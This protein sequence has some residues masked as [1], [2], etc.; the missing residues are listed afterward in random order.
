MNKKCLIVSESFLPL[1]I[2][3]STR[4]FVLWYKNRADIIDSHE[5]VYLRSKYKN[6]PCPSVVRTKQKVKFFYDQVPLTKYNIFKRDNHECVYC[7]SKSNLTIDHVIPKSKGGKDT[8]KNLVT[9]CEP[10]NNAK[11]DLWGD[12]LP[13]EFKIAM[14]TMY[15]PHGLLMMY[16][17]VKIIP[18]EWKPYLFL[19]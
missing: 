1:S 13:D 19:K 16:K 3:D 11:N 6:Y 9:A 10:C 5:G 17:S 4:A 15:K 14:N 7:G 8:W 2:I 12:D 18:E